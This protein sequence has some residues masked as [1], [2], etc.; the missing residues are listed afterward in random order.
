MAESVMSRSAKPFTAPA[1]SIPAAM[2]LPTTTLGSASLSRLPAP[3]TIQTAVVSR[4]FQDF[5]STARA[6]PTPSSARI[7]AFLR[8]RSARSAPSVL[9][10]SQ[11]VAHSI[12]GFFL[13]RLILR[14]LLSP[15]IL[16]VNQHPRLP[17]FLHLPTLFASILSRTK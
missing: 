17:C 10:V 5:H 2:V 8:R 4:S 9:R 12:P 15:L 11:I 1:K 3:S 6:N 13:R 16:H 7:L 14:S